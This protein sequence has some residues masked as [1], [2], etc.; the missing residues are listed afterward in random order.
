MFSNLGLRVSWGITGN[1]E[2]PSGASLEQFSS[3]AYNSIGQSNVANPD[4]KWEKTSQINVGL[5][6]GLF[7]NKVFGS[8]DYYRKNTTDILFQNTAIQPAPASIFIH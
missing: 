8:L 2:F 3:G 5:D 4:L 7:K 1:Q 6:Y